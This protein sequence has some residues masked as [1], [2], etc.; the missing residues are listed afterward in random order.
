MDKTYDVIAETREEWNEL[1]FF[2]DYNKDTK[3]WLLEGSREGLLQFSR[4]LREYASKE[5]N[6]K[7]GEHDHLGPY[8]YLTI[9]TAE[10][11]GIT[12][13]GI[14]GSLINLSQLSD[15][16]ENG[17]KAAATGD[18]IKIDSEY[19]SSNEAVLIMKIRDDGFDPSEPD[20]FAWAKK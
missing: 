12:D 1:V 14:F 3:E 8:S 11:P 6:K 9:V 2:Y 5:S 17:V 7:L 13:Y 4:I 20:D 19:S 10:L 18:I 16:L 15:Q